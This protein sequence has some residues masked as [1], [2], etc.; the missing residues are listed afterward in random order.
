MDYPS[1][2]ASDKKNGAPLG[3]RVHAGSNA[4]RQRA[5]PQG[6][7]SVQGSSGKTCFAEVL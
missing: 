6:V 2:Y 4:L 1:R 7:E 3:A 5:T